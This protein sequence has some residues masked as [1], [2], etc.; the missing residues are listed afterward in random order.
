MSRASS[1]RRNATTPAAEG[2]L[3]HFAGSTLGIAARFAGV[4][5]VLGRTALTRTP[6]DSTSAATAC[7]S[8]TT[9]AFDAAYAAD[10]ALVAGS[11]AAREPMTTMLPC[12]FATIGGRS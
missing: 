12:F 6:A 2:R 10:P 5:I 7:A 8:A 4:S 1:L 3:T 9:A 11:T